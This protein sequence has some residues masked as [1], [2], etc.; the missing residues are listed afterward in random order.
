MYVSV[1]A[2]DFKTGAD[3]PLT[4]EV[5][6]KR[7]IASVSIGGVAGIGGIKKRTRPVLHKTAAAMAAAA[8]VAAQ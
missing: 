1:K 6:K 5:S 4:P 3:N 2:V 7:P 8:A